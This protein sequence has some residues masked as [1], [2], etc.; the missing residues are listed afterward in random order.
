MGFF[1][2][3]TDEMESFQGL[4]DINSVTILLPFCVI[5]CSIVYKRIIRI[6]DGTHALPRRDD[7][8]GKRVCVNSVTWVRIPLSPHQSIDEKSPK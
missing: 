6:T 7:T 1:I 5:K 4:F 3:R 2:Y 8:L